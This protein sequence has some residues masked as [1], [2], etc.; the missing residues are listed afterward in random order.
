MKKLTKSIIISTSLLMAATAPA[1]SMK[2][3]EH[4][5]SDKQDMQMGMN[6][7]GK[8]MHMMHAK[9]KA[10]K[11]EV[12]AIKEEKD[13]VKQREMMKSHMQSIMGMMHMMHEK[14]K[15][16]PMQTQV[17]MAEKHLKMMEMMMSKMEDN[18]SPMSEKSQTNTLGGDHE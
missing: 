10:M 8:D 1:Q 15:K 4:Q 18:H 14:M 7:S 9:M 2:G 16:Q 12:H 17:N 5:G 6:M 11:E 13:P 3:H